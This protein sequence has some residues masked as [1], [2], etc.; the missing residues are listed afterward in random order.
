MGRKLCNRALTQEEAAAK[1]AEHAVSQAK[2]V[3]KIALE[4]WLADASVAAMRKLPEEQ[5]KENLKVVAGINGWI[6][7]KGTRD[8]YIMLQSL[9]SGSLTPVV[10]R[11]DLSYGGPGRLTYRQLHQQLRSHLHL[12]KKVS[13]RVWTYKPW[14]GYSILVVLAE[15]ALRCDD[16]QC[17]EIWGTTLLYYTHL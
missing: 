2:T 4:R 13:L 14:H 9:I 16:K 11:L 12:E 15:D 3:A 17:K 6:K 7:M 5:R 1:A 8:A 10:L